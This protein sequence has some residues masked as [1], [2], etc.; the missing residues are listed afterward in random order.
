MD[1]AVVLSAPLFAGIET[2]AALALLAKMSPRELA[3]GEAVFREGESGDCLFVIGAGT[4]K[5]GRRSNDGR[6]N[7]D[8]KSV[9]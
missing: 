9:V 2:D 3:R 8:R 5:L 6:E 7:L 4:V 1:D